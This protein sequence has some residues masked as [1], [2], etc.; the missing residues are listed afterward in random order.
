[1]ALGV[2][3]IGF[4][5]AGRVLHAPL[6]A[7]SGM[8]IRAVLTRR[9]EDVAAHVPDAEVTT[10][11]DRLVRRDD[12]D[13]VVVAS[14][15]ALHAAHARAALEADKHVVIDKPAATTAADVRALDAMA[16][17]R[18]RVASVF[19]NR[20]WDC[21]FLTLRRV[22][23]RGEIGVPN[24]FRTTWRRHRAAPRAV[25]RDEPGPGSGV[26]LDLGSHMLDQ[27]LQLFGRPE[28]VEA[29]VFRQRAPIG[30]G[31]DQADDGFEVLMGRG[32]LR[33][34][35]AASSLAAGPARTF[36]LDGS[37]G[38]FVKSGFDPQEGQ[39]VAGATPGAPGFGVEPEANWGATWSPDGAHYL[40]PSERGDWS[41]FY[42]EARDTVETGTAPPVTLAEAAEVVEIIELVRQA[43]AER[44]RID[45]V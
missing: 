33:I 13:L 2:G 1:M 39:L 41:R 20:R 21:D 30:V 24:G 44:R 36:R 17:E 4:G 28:W 45:I 7:A 8:A 27:I 38:S 26:L 14:P 22:L 31:A 43:S 34:S 29:D 3:L 25:W 42:I 18:G 5:L 9:A 15:T 23:E 37:E 11:L 6:I 10:D 16:Q 12:V 19:H 32:M 40:E 35:C